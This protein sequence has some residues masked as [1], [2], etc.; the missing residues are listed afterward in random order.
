MRSLYG[1]TWPIARWAVVQRISFF[2]RARLAMQNLIRS[3]LNGTGVA[4]LDSAITTLSFQLQSCFQRHNSWVPELE[5]DLRSK[6]HV[7]RL[8][9]ADARSAEEVAYSVC[10]EPAGSYGAASGR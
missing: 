2:G 3:C 8:A 5:D 9:R 10:Y 4:I 6:L 7:E 1:L